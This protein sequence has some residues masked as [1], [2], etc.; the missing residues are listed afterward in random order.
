[1]RGKRGVR[2]KNNKNKDKRSAEAEQAR[3][4]KAIA[5]SNKLNSSGAASSAQL[6]AASSN[7]DPADAE[8]NSLLTYPLPSTVTRVS[9]DSESDYQPTELDFSSTEENLS[10]APIPGNPASGPVQF[11]IARSKW[12]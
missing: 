8:A 11:G 2:G 3:L 6:G 10:I 12:L 7:T 4:E 9:I 5:K 1:M